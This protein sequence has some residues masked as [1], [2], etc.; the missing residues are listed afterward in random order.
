ML[1]NYYYILLMLI[2]AVIPSI[3]LIIFLRDRIVIKNLAISL[4]VLFVIG[5]IWDQ[6]SV[7]LGIWSFSQE[8]IIGNLFGIP[9][10]EY[11]FII[12]VPIL[13]IMVYT[14]VNKINKN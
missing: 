12:F 2:F 9:F 3:L 10:E 8:K 14:I 5:F 4:I 7:R 13:S 1:E 6:I 11:I